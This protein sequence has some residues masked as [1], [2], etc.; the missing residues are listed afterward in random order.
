MDGR[1]SDRARRWILVGIVAVFIG[2]FLIQNLRW[3]S[4]DGGGGTTDGHYTRA[5][6]LYTYLGTGDE[7]FLRR[8]GQPLFDDIVPS[9][10]SSPLYIGYPPLTYSV[11]AAFF[12]CG[13]VS[14]RSARLSF[15]LFA[16]I[17]LLSLFGI[18][19]ELGRGAF[20]GLAVMALGAASPPLLDF[21]VIYT[22]DYPQTALT[23]LCLY[24][25]LRSDG[26]RRRRPT[27]LL[28]LAVAGALMVK[29]SAALFLAIPLVWCAV[30]NLRRSRRVAAAAGLWAGGVAALGVGLGLAWFSSGAPD[31]WTENHR[32][33]VFYV[34]GCLAPAVAL[35]G[36]AV[37]W[38]RRAS[39]SEHPADAA[40]GA[41]LNMCRGTAVIAVLVGPWYFW[42]MGEL[43][44]YLEI[45]RDL[46][47]SRTLPETMAG[48]GGLLSGAFSLAPILLVVGVGVVARAG[49]RR[50]L[51][52]MFVVTP[53]VVGAALLHAA[54][55]EAELLPIDRRVWLSLYVFT[56]VIG[57]AWVGFTGRAGPYLA[58]VLVMGAGISLVAW[59]GPAAV[60]TTFRP[61]AYTLGQNLS[62]RPVRRSLPRG[63]DQG[64][65]MLRQ[66]LATPDATSED[67]RA[68]LVIFDGRARIFH[69]EWFEA[70]YVDA[71]TRGRR[72][73]IAKL[74]HDHR[75]DL[76]P[77][78]R[79]IDRRRALLDE[80]VYVHRR[81]AAGTALRDALAQ[82]AD[83][84]GALETFPVED[85]LFCSFLQLD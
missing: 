6:N 20:G 64:A 32:W 50:A 7:R 72:L 47:A 83:G 15:S 3:I 55:Q 63:G 74:R 27:A 18:G 30:P 68:V 2:L 82:H 8:Y 52:A 43:R 62:P 76:G 11:T 58:A 38:A 60:E 45:N 53:L 39:A 46:V 61:P 29:W 26:F 73:I 19:H 67:V 10:T 4:F 44:Y 33:G 49:S 14:M 65:Q 42:N 21:S 80:I 36:G 85:R 23:A 71:L 66:R 54:V 51:W 5:A 13:G 37:W 31:L 84:V 81:R 75:E 17:L 34:F 9:T 70:V 25:L 1:N 77:V 24:L 16:V 40:T 28:A 59:G 57:G 79:E 69:P 35:Y 56:A 78:L 12:A 48:L 41:W 22:L